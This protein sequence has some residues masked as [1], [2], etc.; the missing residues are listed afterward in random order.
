MKWIVKH[1]KR[2]ELSD[3]HYIFIHEIHFLT[4][5]ISLELEWSFLITVL[6]G[7]CLSVRFLSVCP[8]VNFKLFY[9]F[10]KILCSILTK[11][12]RTI[13]KLGQYN[14]IIKVFPSL[15]G[16]SFRILK[17]FWHF[18]ISSFQKTCLCEK[19]PRV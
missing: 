5:S 9:Y 17:T 6:S 1:F 18:I 2:L 15:K 4:Y 13:S 7:V 10:S 14:L 3:N 11:N 8:S 19:H 12:I 16:R